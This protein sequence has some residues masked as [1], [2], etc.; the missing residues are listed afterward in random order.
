M[1][2]TLTNIKNYRNLPINHFLYCR[3][4]THFTFHNLTHYQHNTHTN[5]NNIFTQHQYHIIKFN[6]TQNQNINTAFTQHFQHQLQ[7]FLLTI[8]NTNI[9]IFFTH[10]FTQHKITFHT[11]TQ[12]TNTNHFLQLTQNI[13]R[14]LHYL[15]NIKNNKIITTTLY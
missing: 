15:F 1:L 5:L 8:N 10:Q 4:F 13:Y 11:N 2:H 14:T 12:K 7:T 9:K 3:H 6:F